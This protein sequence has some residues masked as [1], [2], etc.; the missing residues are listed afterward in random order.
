MCWIVLFTYELGERFPSGLIF[1]CATAS[2]MRTGSLA[3]AA[4]V[5]ADAE[6]LRSIGGLWDEEASAEY[7][8]FG[9]ASRSGCGGASGGAGA[10]ATAV[11]MML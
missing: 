9:L 4:L 7:T 1:C 5:V 8:D 6:V 10:A 3:D 11:D 2:L